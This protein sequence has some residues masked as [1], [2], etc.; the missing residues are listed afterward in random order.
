MTLSRLVSLVE[1]KTVLIN[2]LL[3]GNIKL[4]SEEESSYSSAEDSSHV[5][6]KDYSLT[7]H[8]ANIRVR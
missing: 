5:R 4:P 6:S 2:T 1:N 3:N 7:G 8:Q